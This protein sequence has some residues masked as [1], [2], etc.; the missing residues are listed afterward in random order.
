MIA[1][2]GRRN[3]TDRPHWVAV[4]D[5]ANLTFELIEITRKKTGQRPV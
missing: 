4:D 2:I 3:P 5:Q 1:D